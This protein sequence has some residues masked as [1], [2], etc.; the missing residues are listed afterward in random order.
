ME[1]RHA[2]AQRQKNAD[3]DENRPVCSQHTEREDP[4]K[5]HQEAGG[6]GQAPGD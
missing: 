3:K 6:A 4:G 1:R 5:R 2:K